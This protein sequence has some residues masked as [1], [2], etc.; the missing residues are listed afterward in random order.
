MKRGS[1]TCQRKISEAEKAAACHEG[2][3]FCEDLAE[4]GQGL[5]YLVGEQR[6]SRPISRKKAGGTES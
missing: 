6:W 1:A 2:E 5:V 4:G 3:E